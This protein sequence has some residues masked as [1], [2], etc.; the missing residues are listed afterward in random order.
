MFADWG[1]L[2]ASKFSWVY[3]PFQF[4]SGAAGLPT[5]QFGSL[6]SGHSNSAVIQMKKYSEKVNTE[7]KKNAEEKKNIIDPTVGTFT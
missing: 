5:G 2:A 1:D 7:L 3:F 4:M 6:F